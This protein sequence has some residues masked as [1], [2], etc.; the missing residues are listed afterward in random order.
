MFQ[1]FTNA[2][3]RALSAEIATELAALGA[4]YGLSIT[5]GGGQ[6]GASELTIKV[7]AKT[8]DPAT[9]ATEAQ[10]AFDQGARWVRSHSGD[11]LQGSDLGCN[12]NYNN[13]RWELVG[14]KPNRPKYP[15]QAKCLRTGKE[16]KLP[17]GA[18]IAIIAERAGSPAVP[19]F[20]TAQP[21]ITPPGFDPRYANVAT[22]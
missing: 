2:G 1:G 18:I 13:S 22:F 3:H 14:V 6:V 8:N 10:R 5:A 20:Q 9:A 7:V 16:Y 19:V 12:F 17:V 15:I 21:Q 4:R 11:T